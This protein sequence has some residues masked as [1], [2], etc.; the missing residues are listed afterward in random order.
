MEDGTKEHARGHEDDDVGH[1]RPSGQPIGQKGE[2]H[3][4]AQQAEERGQAHRVSILPGIGR[5]SFEMGMEHFSGPAELP[6]TRFPVTWQHCG[7]EFSAGRR[8]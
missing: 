5:F 1:A 4:P 6:L 8:L 7:A 2:D 3:D